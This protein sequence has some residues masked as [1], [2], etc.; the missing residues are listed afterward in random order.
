MF[1]SIMNVLEELNTLLAPALPVETGVFSEAAPAEYLVLTPLTDSFDL[2][3]DGHPLM[4]VCEVRI[5][6]FSKGNYLARKKQITEI[7]LDGDFTITG[8]YFARHEDDTGYYHYC[9]DA[10]KEYETED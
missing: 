3:A 1:D 2:F 9:I 6:L 4:D 7:L 5:S 8:R 10:A